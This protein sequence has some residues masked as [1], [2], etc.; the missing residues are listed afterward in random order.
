M[1]RRRWNSRQV[2]EPKPVLT[3][4][5][6][7]A[8][9]LADRKRKAKVATTLIG[10]LDA[11]RIGVT[12]EMYGENDRHDKAKRTIIY[13]DFDLR[14]D[15][16]GGEI[17]AC[18]DEW[19]ENW[20]HDDFYA[21]GKDLYRIFHSKLSQAVNAK[22]GTTELTKLTW[23]IKAGCAC[24]CSPGWNVKDWTK[25]EDEDGNTI[26]WWNQHVW[27]SFYIL[28]DEE[29]AEKVAERERKAAQ[30]KA[31]RNADILVAAFEQR[32]AALLA[33]ALEEASMKDEH[34]V[35]AWTGSLY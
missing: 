32:K 9:R 19:R 4:E 8:K 12:V 10:Q 22:F 6:L 3:E 25:L 14:K 29:Y 7:K 23:N 24:G 16:R 2:K 31:Q 17:K 27:L 15:G 21:L 11:D 34:G 28:T 5:E 20:T 30:E 33:Q 26:S 1:S 35:L 18:D 13:R